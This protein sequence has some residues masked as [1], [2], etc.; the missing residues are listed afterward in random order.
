MDRSISPQRFSDE[1]HRYEVLKKESFL[2]KLTL[3]TILLLS[4]LLLLGSV[5]FVRAQ[6]VSPYFG[7]GTARDR[8]GTTNNVCPAGQLFDGL[9]CEAGPTMGG[10]FGVVGVDFM[11]K[12]HLGING[13]YAFR[14]ARAPFL[15][16]DGL[17]MRPAFYDLNA[18]WQPISGRRI[19]PFLEGGIGGARVFLYSTGASITG[20]AGTSGFPAG[21]DT[22]HF[23]LHFAAGLKVYIKGNLFIKPQFDLHYARHLTDQFGRNVVVQFMGSVGYTFGGR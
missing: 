12:K 3:R 8:A 6:R 23:Q 4:I 13:E 14:F 10:L 21:S 22:S 7:L 20:V 16:G 2:S 9:L 15:A 5:N 17:K 18:L 19:A 11:F 1:R